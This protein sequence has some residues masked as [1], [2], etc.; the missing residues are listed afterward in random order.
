MLAHSVWTAR[1]YTQILHEAL[2]KSQLLPVLLGLGKQE[3]WNSTQGKM[4]TGHE[5][6]SSRK[7][8]EI[9]LTPE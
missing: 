6:Q 7:G 9:W 3:H 1:I 5:Y 2:Y 8:T 4:N